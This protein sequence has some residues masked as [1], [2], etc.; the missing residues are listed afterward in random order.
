MHFSTYTTCYSR[1]GLIAKTR[2][3]HRTIGPISKI[4][5]FKP[6]RKS[7][8]MSWRWFGSNSKV[9]S[10]KIGGFCE[11][12]ERV[13]RPTNV[14]LLKGQRGVKRCGRCSTCVRN[15]AR[16][17]HVFSAN[18]G[19]CVCVDVWLIYL[20]RRF[21]VDLN[22]CCKVMVKFKVFGSYMGYRCRCIMSGK[23]FECLFNM[24]WLSSWIYLWCMSW[25]FYMEDVILLC[26]V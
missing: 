8:S 4:F 22:R 7:L 23:L 13:V 14:P 20:R 11:P 9:A 19:V 1:R 6:T 24:I 10:W 21:D 15:Y 18:I 25:F 12:N 16:C 5:F 17:V 2:T 26:L 3:F